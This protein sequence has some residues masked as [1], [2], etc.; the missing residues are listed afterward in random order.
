VDFSF[1]LISICVRP[2]RTRFRHSL[3]V[4]CGSAVSFE[5]V[6]VALGQNR[7]RESFNGVLGID[8]DLRNIFANGVY[9]SNGDGEEDLFHELALGFACGPAFPR[10]T[11]AAFPVVIGLPWVLRLGRK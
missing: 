7:G 4:L 2:W 9:G 10:S 1:R 11:G 8:N 5:L 6:G 3:C